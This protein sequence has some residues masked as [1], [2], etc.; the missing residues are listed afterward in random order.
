MGFPQ[1]TIILADNSKIF[2]NHV[3][4]LLDRMGFNVITASDGVQAIKAVNEF[5]PDLAILELTLPKI[6]GVKA[7]RQ[8]KNSKTTFRTPIVVMSVDRKKEIIDQCERYGC[9]GFIQKPIM[10]DALHDILQDCIFAPA[11]IRRKYARAVFITDVT[12]TKGRKKLKTQ[13]DNI[14]SGGIYVRS[15]KIFAPGDEVKVAFSASNREKMSLS[16]TIVYIN[17]SDAASQM[18]SGMA[19]EFKGLPEKSSAQLDTLVTNLL[20][21]DILE[22]QTEDVVS[23]DK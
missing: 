3:S 23:L 22:C 15:D 17:T 19:I 5:S 13:S 14:S 11:G 18:S 7:L 6:D 10:L 12:V 4:I 20:I 1:K 8:I 16:G 9:A 21:G 2:L